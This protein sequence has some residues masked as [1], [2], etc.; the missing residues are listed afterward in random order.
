[1]VVRA[2]SLSCAVQATQK[3]PWNETIQADWIEQFYTLC[4]AH[5]AVE[6]ITWW[7][8]AERGHFWPH[9][10]FLRPDMHPKESYQR[11]LKLRKSW[12]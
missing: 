5:P 2:I 11:L 8:F 3:W 1:V 10:G 4:Y 7:D 9:G 6:A 12:A